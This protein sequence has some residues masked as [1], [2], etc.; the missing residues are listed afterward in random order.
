MRKRQTLSRSG[1]ALTTVLVVA[2]GAT[3]STAGTASP[4]PALRPKVVSQNR[5]ATPG[6]TGTFDLVQQV[7]EYPPG[8]FS[9]KHSH[10]GPVLITVLEGDMTMRAE[11]GDSTVAVGKSF[12]EVPG[13]VYQAGNN[14]SATVKWVA[15]IFVPAG[16]AVS[17][18]VA[19]ATPVGPAVT[20]TFTYRWKG[21]SQTGSYDLVQLVQDFEPGARTPKHKHGGAGVITVIEGELTLRANGSDTVYKAGES[22]IEE[23]GQ[24]IEGINAGGA[25]ARTVAS[26]LLP[27]GVEL[28]TTVK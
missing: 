11:D 6:V 16:A 20:P 14:T 13:K 27:V 17:T 18:P 1:L 10:A 24:V 15:D 9:V 2:C 19:G 5:L 7:V 21:L 23:A 22:F 4:S 12:S 25:T 3:S 28:T 8:S 26:F